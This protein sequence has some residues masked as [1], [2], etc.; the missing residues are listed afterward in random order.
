MRNP[1]DLKLGADF[2]HVGFRHRAYENRSAEARVDYDRLFESVKEHGM[3][4]PL[5]IYQDCVLI[6]MRRCEIARRLN[7]REVACLEIEED[8]NQEPND[9]RVAEMVKEYAPVEY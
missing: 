7:I 3:K 9:K 6:G 8:M 4:N 2:E 1:N 5:I